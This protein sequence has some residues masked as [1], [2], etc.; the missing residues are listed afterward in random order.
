F[1]VPVPV[2]SSTNPDLN[3]SAS[4]HSLP[5]RT[6]GAH[7]TK[8][9]VGRLDAL[10]LNSEG[11]SKFLPQDSPTTA[12]ARRGRRGTFGGKFTVPPPIPSSNPD[13]NPS[14]STNSLPDRVH[15][16]HNTKHDVGRLDALN[17]NSEGASKASKHADKLLGI[18]IH[19]VVDR[20]DALNTYKLAAKGWKVFGEELQ[21]DPNIKTWDHQVAG[22]ADKKIFVTETY[23]AAASIACD[24]GLITPEQLYETCMTATEEFDDVRCMYPDRKANW[25]E[26]V[27]DLKTDMLR[28][29]ETLDRTGWT[30]NN[31]ECK[32]P[33]ITD[34]NKLFDDD[35]KAM[36]KTM[37]EHK[38]RRSV[39]D[40][41]AITMEP[42]PAVAAKTSATRT[43][44]V[45]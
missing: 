45:V 33:D 5:D 8:H 15:G 37:Q 40:S 17:L 14:A 1:S 7:N 21:I 25:D 31:M 32:I 19:R 20:G 39:R 13:L 9:D 2:P 24:N 36:A 4:T 22:F 34:T 27:K 28:A 38:S 42:N 23:V 41:R 11:A 43:G 26:A 30:A 3:P 35:N 16:A 29:Q 44:D 6:H 18:F 10:N 12:A